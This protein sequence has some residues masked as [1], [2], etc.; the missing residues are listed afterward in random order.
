MWLFDSDPNTDRE[1]H[2]KVAHESLRGLL[3]AVV[4]DDECWIFL[5]LF[6]VLVEPESRKKSG[7]YLPRVLQTREMFEPRKHLSERAKRPGWQRYNINI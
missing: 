5:P 7:W 1:G 3:G 4:V 2:H 6:I